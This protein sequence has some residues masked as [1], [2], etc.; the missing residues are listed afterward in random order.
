M[1]PLK[2]II[3]ASLMLLAIAGG[4]LGTYHYIRNARGPRERAFAIRM[5]SVCWLLVAV[6]IAAVNLTEGRVRTLVL[7]GF[8]IVCPALFYR[9]STRLQL[10]RMVDRR[11]RDDR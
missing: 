7:A 11:E 2:I 5:L 4:T 10:I 8:F 9:W 6:M 3:G 1:P